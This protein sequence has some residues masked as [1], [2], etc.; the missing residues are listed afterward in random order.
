MPE[1]PEVEAVCRN[2]R[3]DAVG[4]SIVQL[5]VE[6]A[7]VTRPQDPA[8]LEQEAA[9]RRI[10]S[11]ERR[12]KNILLHLSGE[13]VLHVHLRMTGNLYVI[14]D[15]RF[16]PSSVRL[17]ME[18]D[19]GRGLIYEDSRVLGKVHLHRTAD[20][21]GVLKGVGVEPLSDTFSLESFRKMAKASGVPAKLFLMD[22]RRVAGLGNIY[23][24][25]ALFRAGVNP[26]KA[27]R[28]VTAA[29]LTRLYEVIVEVLREAL[30]SAAGAYAEPGRF[31]EGESF[32]CAVYDREGEPC[33]TCGRAIRRIPQ[34]GRSTYYCPGCQR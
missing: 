21:R 13:H 11:V 26:R 18:L 4:A 30:D 34:G 32:P 25:E 19:G 7:S 1:L 33:L 27:I 6:R 29:K 14:P 24:A 10:E 2:L 22:Q 9:G 17:W 3:R 28:R 16:R 12:G 15:V 8:W 23:A 20:L 31:V 5:R